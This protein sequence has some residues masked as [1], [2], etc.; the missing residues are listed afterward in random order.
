MAE[1]VR[2]LHLTCTMQQESARQ[3]QALD[4]VGG[5]WYSGPR[6]GR[7]AGLLA[8][9][10]KAGKRKGLGSGWEVDLDS[11]W[12]SGAGIRRRHEEKLIGMET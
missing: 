4:L 6:S 5:R 11:A 12:Q 2:T 10:T 8:V 9:G 1:C 7:G 3:S